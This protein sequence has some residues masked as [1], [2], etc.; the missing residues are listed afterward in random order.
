MTTLSYN[1]TITIVGVGAL[2]SHLVQF[3]RNE[4]QL[5]VIDFD[6]VENKNILSQFFSKNTN[7]QNKS[8]AIAQM[9]QYLWGIK[10]KATPHKMTKDN[11]S[12]LFKNSNLIIDCLDNGESRKILQDFV[13]STK[14]K[15]P[16]LHGALAPNGEFGRVVWDEKFII[17][18]EGLSGAPTCEVG[19]FLP[20]ISLTSAYLAYSAQNFLKSEQKIGFE[21]TPRGAFSS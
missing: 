11:I 14:N 1:K 18:N 9:T 21:I 2:G 20:F 6:R 17:D 10:I 4:G 5:E 8:N 19:E 15:I 3:L 13:R 7:N 12:V 16:L